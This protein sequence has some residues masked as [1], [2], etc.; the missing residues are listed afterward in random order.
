MRA[1]L[2]VV[3]FF[4][5]VGCGPDLPQNS[6]SADSGAGRTASTGG[7]SA[8][9]FSCQQAVNGKRLSC[10][11]YQWTGGAYS[12]ASWSSA[13]TASMGQVGSGC[14]RSGSAGGCRMTT[15]ANPV[16]IT[17]TTWFFPEAYPPGTDLAQ[18][19]RSGC[20]TGQVLSP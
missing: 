8:G 10:T 19:V 18:A 17:T 1:L 14:L 12:T 2:S 6:G 5:I 9:T 15:T 13:C 20:P 7:P 3:V 11:D 16:T 4:G